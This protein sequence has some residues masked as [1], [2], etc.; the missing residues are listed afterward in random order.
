MIFTTSVQACRLPLRK[1]TTWL[2]FLYSSI[3]TNEIFH[4]CE[5]LGECS[6]VHVYLFRNISSN[7]LSDKNSRALD[8]EQSNAGQRQK[9]F[10]CNYYKLIK[11]ACSTYQSLDFNLLNRFYKQ[12]VKVISHTGNWT[13]ASWVKAKYPSH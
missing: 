3:F 10:A 7:Y 8:Y 5:E 4:L 11:C 13:R 2:R 12:N 9:L 6:F 1:M